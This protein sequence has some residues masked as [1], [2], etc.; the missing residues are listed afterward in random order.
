MSFFFPLP[1]RPLRETALLHLV[2]DRCDMPNGTPNNPH[3]LYV[4][5]FYREKIGIARKKAQK[6]DLF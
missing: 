6:N 2:K 5:A 4:V 1:V 3:V